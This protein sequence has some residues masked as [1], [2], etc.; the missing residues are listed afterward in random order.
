MTTR[1]KSR[2]R[3]TYSSI[4]ER[5]VVDP[6]VTVTATEVLPALALIYFTKNNGDGARYLITRKVPANLD[7]TISST[8][9]GH[10]QIQYPTVVNLS[11]ADALMTPNGTTALETAVS[12]GDA[13]DFFM[14]NDSGT[15]TDSNF[16]VVFY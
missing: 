1:D 4:R 11:S 9:A 12:F 5:P 15:A 13:I 8:A 16:L 10:V 2:S 7:V 14:K 6:I 3:R